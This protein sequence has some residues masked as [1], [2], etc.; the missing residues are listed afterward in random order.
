MNMKNISL[1]NRGTKF[2][3]CVAVASLLAI[4]PMV[5][6]QDAPDAPVDSQDKEDA[7]PKVKWPFEDPKG[8]VRL[9][10]TARIWVVPKT[11][12]VIV[13]GVVCLRDGQLEMFACPKGSKEHESVIS[14]QARPST[15]HAALLAI[16]AMP[17][18]PV[19]TRPIYQAATGTE[20]DIKILWKDN[21]GKLHEDNAM[22]WVCDDHTG[23]ALKTPWVFAGSGFWIDD[24]NRRRYYADGGEF[25]CVSNFPTAMLDLPVASTREADG[26]LYRAFTENIPALQTK[27]RL[28]L[29]PKLP[30][31]KG[32]KETD[33]EKPPVE[34]KEPLKELPLTEPADK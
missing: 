23:K 24:N 6:A 29:T 27:V 18:S 32:E 9:S 21:R 33:K 10:K 8:G 13:D 25:I 4:G 12:Q 22:D 3:A 15:A 14:V 7:L 11:K 5:L 16:G 30:K 31:K 28:V 19:Q 17:G 2:F 34:K 20:I 26:L 1:L